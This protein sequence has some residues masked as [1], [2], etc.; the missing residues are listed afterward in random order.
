M[1]LI[2]SPMLDA[3]AKTTNGTGGGDGT[4]TIEIGVQEFTEPAQDAHDEHGCF[5]SSV[6]LL[7]V[8]VCFFLLKSKCPFPWLHAALLYGVARDG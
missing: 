1:L 3:R 8:C 7:C 2:G 4:I 6:A 5:G